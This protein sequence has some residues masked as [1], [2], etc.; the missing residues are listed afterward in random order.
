M[1]LILGLGVML[2]GCS[3]YF[4]ETPSNNGSDNPAATSEGMDLVGTWEYRSHREV[5][6]DENS[7]KGRLTIDAERCFASKSSCELS[8]QVEFPAP[9]DRLE[10]QVH[11]IHGRSYPDEGFVKFSYTVPSELL[12]D[13]RLRVEVTLDRMLA[14]EKHPRAMAGYTVIF[15]QDRPGKQFDDWDIIDAAG[16]GIADEAGRVTAWPVDAE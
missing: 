12:S 1:A 2:T 11:E 9:V 14:T 16:R 13:D 15:N 3:G 10:D 4:S 7:V 6:Q 8:G 5:N